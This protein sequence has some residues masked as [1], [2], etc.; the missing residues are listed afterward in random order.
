MQDVAYYLEIEEPNTITSQ[1]ATPL[2]FP[3]A[4]GPSLCAATA[5]VRLELH[6]LARYDMA[7]RAGERF[8]MASNFTNINSLGY[9]DG[10]WI[11]GLSQRD[12]R[13]R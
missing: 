2:P 6:K 11:R 4:A 1:L 8:L 13:C 7:T 10:D 5:T 3:C 12:T 9:S